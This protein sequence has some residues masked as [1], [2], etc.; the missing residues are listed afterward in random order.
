[1]EDRLN[2]MEEAVQTLLVSRASTEQF[3]QS[4]SDSIKQI[5]DAIKKFNQFQAQTEVHRQQ[6]VSFRQEVA[7]KLDRM[8]THRTRDLDIV[9][10]DIRKQ[11]NR[12]NLLVKDVSLVI[13]KLN[14]TEEDLK[15]HT[16]DDKTNHNRL[17]SAMIT[18]FVS[19]IVAG[20][21]A[22]IAW[23]FNSSPK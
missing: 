13:Q 11:E 2:K 9:Y 7:E 22:G 1:M 16:D 8:L 4:V 17:K 14:A 12:I 18:G 5:A 19:V 21:I 20:T 23:V 3:N 15:E 6:D 10:K